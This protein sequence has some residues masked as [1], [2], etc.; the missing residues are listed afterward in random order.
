MNIVMPIPNTVADFLNLPVFVVNLAIATNRFHTVAPRIQQA[1][2]KNIFR[3]LGIHGANHSQRMTAY[4]TL[5]NPRITQ[6]D[7]WFLHSAGRQGCLLSHLLLWRQMIEQNIPV[8]VVLEDDVCFHSRWEEILPEYLEKIPQDV[9][10]VYLGCQFRQSSTGKIVD[11]IE[12]ITTHA[13]VVTLEGAKI[14]FDTLMNEPDGLSTL[15]EMIHYKVMKPRKI[16]WA[17]FDTQYPEYE[18]PKVKQMPPDFQYRACGLIFQDPA[19]PT[20]I[21]RY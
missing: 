17:T 5:G 11:K 15:D 8:A 1:G 6:K 3:Y 18:D 13:Y 20:L 9:D 4:A 2:F 10:L 16:N 14:L 12:C 19:F 21:E 7:M